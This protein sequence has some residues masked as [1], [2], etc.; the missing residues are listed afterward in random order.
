MPPT[1]VEVAKAEPQTVRDRFRALG[2]LESERLIA[3]VSEINGVIVSLPFEEG[4]AVDEGALIAQLDEREILAQANRAEAQRDRAVS[5]HERAT[6]L[7]EEKAISTKELEDASTALRVAEADLELAR[8]RLAKARIRA[9]FSGLAGRR[10]VSPGAYVSTG[11]LITELARVDVMRVT[12]AAPERYVGVLKPGIPVAI[13]TP[14]YPGL[15]FTG[16]LSVVDPIVDPNTRTVQLVAHVPNRERRLRPGMSADV[17]VTLAER[18]KAL[19]VPDEAVFAQGNENFV[20]VVKADSTVARVAIR[21]GTRD[22][23]QVEVLGGIDAGVMVVRAGHQ[24]L[25]DGARVMPVSNMGGAAE[26]PAAETAEQPGDEGAKKD[27][28]PAKESGA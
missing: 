2:S 17:L 1:P 6:K 12:F 13:E 11:D 5:D 10:R 18:S 22:S 19:V 14:A 26:P 24:K 16:R 28:A 20:Y 23:S 9:P 4:Q 8:A 21:L 27:E 7:F 25:F 3:V 15:T